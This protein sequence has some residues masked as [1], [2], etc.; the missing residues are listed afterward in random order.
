MIATH[1]M[2]HI[3]QTCRN[4]HKST[5]AAMMIQDCSADNTSLSVVP[6]EQSPTPVKLL[7]ISAPITILEHHHAQTPPHHQTMS[8]SDPTVSKLTIQTSLRSLHPRQGDRGLG[9]FHEG[10]ESI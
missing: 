8:C 9:S 1:P 3:T 4:C 6:R 5:P 10:G 2:G 7:M